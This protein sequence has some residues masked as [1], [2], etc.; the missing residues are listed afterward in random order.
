MERKRKPGGA[1]KAREKK[2]KSLL[3]DAAKCSKITDMFSPKSVS[4][5][6]DGESSGE[7]AGTTRSG[8]RGAV[9]HKINF[10][11]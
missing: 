10:T 4:V 11:S 8:E 9:S 2:R 3:E 6:D 5:G 1:E 7:K